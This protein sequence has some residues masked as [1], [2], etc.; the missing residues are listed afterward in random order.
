MKEP[1]TKEKLADQFPDVFRGTGKPSEP[2]HL[3]IDPSAKPAVHPPR[4]VPLALETAPKEEL[5]RL[6]S[7][8]ILTPVSEPAPWVSSMVIVKKLNGNI[9]VCLDP[10]DLNKVLK[11]SHYPMPTID[12]ILPELCRAKVF[13]VFDVIYRF[14]QG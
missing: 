8:Q 4:K 7:L 13:S 1:L 6:E 10:K 9:R 14:S 12:D 3:Q 11:R 2:Y 5:G